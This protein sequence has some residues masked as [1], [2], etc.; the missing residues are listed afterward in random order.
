MVRQLWEVENRAELLP[1]HESRCPARHSRPNIG[2]I[3]LPARGPKYRI[4]F[5]KTHAQGNLLQTQAHDST[6]QVY[7]VGPTQVSYALI[8][9]PAYH[10]GSSDP[11]LQLIPGIKKAGRGRSR[12]VS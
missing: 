11:N 2:K 5:A 8:V 7:W 3:S 4:K 10:A 1:R 12:T 6:D 9:M